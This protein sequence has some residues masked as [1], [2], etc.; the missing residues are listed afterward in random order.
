MIN[1]LLGLALIS[2]PT[3]V[4]GAALYI[5]TKYTENGPLNYGKTTQDSSVKKVT[6]VFNEYNRSEYLFLAASFIIFASTFIISREIFKTTSYKD[7]Q[8][9]KV[10]PF[11]LA[12]IASLGVLL[13]GLPNI[14]KFHPSGG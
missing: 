7:T 14:L 9:A 3:L 10:M 12:L 11:V 2:G 1:R 6:S 5:G 13:I 4:T 8:L